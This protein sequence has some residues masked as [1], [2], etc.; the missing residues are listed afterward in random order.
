[1]IF[2]IIVKATSKNNIRRLIW[3]C[4]VCIHAHAYIRACVYGYKCVSACG[5]MRAYMYV[6]ASSVCLS[7]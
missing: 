1:M 5:Y 4:T 6:R 7:V 2:L 3:V